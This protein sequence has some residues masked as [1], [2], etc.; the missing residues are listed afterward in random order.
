[1]RRKKKV[2]RGIAGGLRWQPMPVG[3]P[4]MHHIGDFSNPFRPACLPK[5]GTTPRPGREAKTTAEVKGKKVIFPRDQNMMRKQEKK[6]QANAHIL[7][8][9]SP[10]PGGIY[11]APKTPGCE[12]QIVET[13]STGLQH[14]AP[15]SLTPNKRDGLT[16]GA[17]TVEEGLH[18]RY[19][20]LRF[21]DERREMGVT[22]EMGRKDGWR[23]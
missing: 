2:K 9:S 4:R 7:S 19:V 12:K 6:K 20:H 17:T 16:V 23:A 18:L 22:K 1:M 11:D 5:P 21:R 14:K 8:P 10:V 15:V 3:S 13:R